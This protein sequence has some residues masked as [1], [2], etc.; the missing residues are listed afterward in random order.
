MVR[1]RSGWLV[2]LAVV[3]LGASACKKDGNAAKDKQAEPTKPETKTTDKPAD[4]AAPSTA[5]ASNP[6][7][8][9]LSLLPVDSDIVMGLNVAQLQESA[10][11]KQF[12][13]KL[14]EKA[15][16][17]LAQFKAACGFDPM[18][19]IKSVSI[20]MKIPTGDKPGGVF[21]IHGAEKS[22]IMGACLDKAKELAAKDGTQ[23]T[24][25][26]DIISLSDKRG[27]PMA[28][29]FV[30]EN[31]LVGAFG[32]NGTKVGVKA[33]AAG[34]S[35]LKTSAAFIDMYSKINTRDS[36]WMLA[37]GNSKLFEQAAALGVKPKAVFGSLNATDGLS[38]DF[39][40]R[41]DTA[42]Q[43]I[44]IT[45]LANAQAA[46]AK[47]FVDKLDIVN[48]GPDVRVSVGLSS[49]KLQQLIQQFGGMLGG[50]RMGNP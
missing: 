18:T 37:N 41:L 33:A 10:L 21:A 25:D 46:G 3:S 27:E 32:A 12:A 49:A 26:G 6:S 38:L 36:L 39:R 29:M 20:G 30:N 50:I 8:D 45:K 15:G 43:A 14:M 22:K 34:G 35:A 31:T 17:G 28:F 13:P 1:I 44:Q 24:V 9:D 42:D 7:G 5:I 23:L 40:M 11:W 19:T 2:A 4:P 48:D 16:P 47:A